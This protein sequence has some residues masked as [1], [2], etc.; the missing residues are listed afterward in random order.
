MKEME[1]R[2]IQSIAG[3]KVIAVWLIF[4]W[5]S[6]L[7]NPPCDLG[8]RCCE[9]FFVASGFFVFLSH[10]NTSGFCTWKASAEYIKKRLI[11]IW[12]VHFLAFCLCLCSMPPADIFTKS[13]LIRG[14]I[15]LTLI[16]SWSNA[17]R[18]FFSFNGPSWFLSSLLFCYF[19]V[20]VLLRMIRRKR[21]ILLLFPVVFLVRYAVEEIGFYYPNEYWIFSVHLSPVLRMMEFFLGMMTGAMWSNVCGHCDKWCKKQNSALIFGGFTVMEAAAL[22]LTGTVWI[23]RQNYWGRAKFV[24]WICAIV[25]LFAFDMGFLSRLLAFKPVRW[26]ASIQFEFFM[27]HIPVINLVSRYM[28]PYGLSDKLLAASAFAIVVFLS[29]MYRFFL[30]KPA[31]VLMRKMLGQGWKW[32]IS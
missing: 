22:Y 6:W 18:T 27:F 23:T 16:Q 28:E 14:L 19:L 32:L 11:S 12:P 17:E 10:Q 24:L 13:T 30:K 7:T 1:N 20:P 15:N 31:E 25:F 5:H 2:Q 3:L 29:K 26:F 8:A 21:K 4:W 9:F